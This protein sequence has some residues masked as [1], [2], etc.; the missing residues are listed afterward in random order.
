MNLG[1]G[2]HQKEVSSTKGLSNYMSCAQYEVYVL[3]KSGKGMWSQKSERERE[4]KKKEIREQRERS[5][6]EMTE[7][8]RSRIQ[9]KKVPRPSQWCARVG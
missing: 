8:I 5:M 7:K 9:N 3:N 6:E 1:M 4:K 2:E